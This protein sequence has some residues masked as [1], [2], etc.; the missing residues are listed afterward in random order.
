[1]SSHNCDED[2]EINIFLIETIKDYPS[3]WIK[4]KDDYT[5]IDDNDWNEIS[6]KMGINSKF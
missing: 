4:E 2:L 1:M 5:L 3:Q 6:K